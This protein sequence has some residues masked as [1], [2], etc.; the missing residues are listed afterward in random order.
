MFLEILFITITIA[1][2]IFGTSFLKWHPIIVLLTGSL[3]LGISLQISLLDVLFQMFE[4]FMSLTKNIGVLILFGVIIGLSLE[5]NGATSVISLGI[6]K[7]F[8]KLPL[9]YIISLIGFIVSIPVFCDAAFIILSTLNKK[10]SELT[11]TSKKTLTIALSTGLFAPHVLVPPTPGPLAVASTLD[12]DNIFL[13]FICGGSL[14]LFLALIGAFYSHNFIEKS[15]VISKSTIQSLIDDLKLENDLTFRLASSPIWLPILLMSIRPLAPESLISLTTPVFSLFVGVF[16]SLYIS[17]RKVQIQPLLIKSLK[18]S[19]PIIAITGAGGALGEIIQNIDVISWF[20]DVNY[21]DSLGIIIPF[22]IAATLK[23]AQGSSTVAMIT[24]AS[25]IYP[26]LFI[27][28]LE[29]ET[30]KIFTI[31]AIGVG[32]M[33][34]SHANDSYFWIVSQM[35]GLDT[36]TAYQT[37][38]IATFI[39]GVSGITFLLIT[40]NLYKLF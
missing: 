16:V 36:K 11:K 37:H 39:Q 10:L 22:I 8:S 5:K 4:G 18:H 29:N 3:L 15:L 28:G 7:I 24:A 9:T 32:S 31:L 30:G 21:F 33:T 40:Y 23:T 38:T 1:W 26:I 34:V 35:S 27:F 19:I 12:L 14:A 20:D 6:L 17:F 13:L 25:I 2:I